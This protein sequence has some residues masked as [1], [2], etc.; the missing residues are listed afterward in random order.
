MLCWTSVRTFVRNFERGVLINVC[1]R[2]YID[3]YIEVHMSDSKKAGRPPA[4]KNTGER[5]NIYFTEPRAELFEKAFNLLREKGK[6][7]STANLR[8]SRTDV[9]DFALDALVEKLEN[10]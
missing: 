2:K 5:V 8:S 3:K 7:P 1:A 9:I 4:G 6:L 10:E